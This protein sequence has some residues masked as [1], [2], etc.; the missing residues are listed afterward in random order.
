MS[1]E[2]QN[3]P[4]QPEIMIWD[5]AVQVAAYRDEMSAFGVAQALGVMYRLAVM[6]AHWAG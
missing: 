1:R 2:K 5:R 6:L 3:Y 4:S